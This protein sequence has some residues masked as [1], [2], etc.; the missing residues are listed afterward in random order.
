M[1]R[2]SFYVNLDKHCRFTEYFLSF[3]FYVY[4]SNIF[5]NHNFIGCLIY[6]VFFGLRLG[7]I[8]EL[9]NIGS[10]PKV[11]NFSFF[12]LFYF[13]TSYIEIKGHFS[14]PIAFMFYYFEKKISFNLYML[15]FFF[16]LTV[17]TSRLPTTIEFHAFS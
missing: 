9:C 8:N 6:E 17:F 14:F 4:L 13:M 7:K 1:S 12:Y 2:F 10:I 15:L 5:K 11:N 3:P 16:C